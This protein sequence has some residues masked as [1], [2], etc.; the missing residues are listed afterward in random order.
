MLSI[1][2]AAVKLYIVAALAFASVIAILGAAWLASVALAVIA[3]VA[4]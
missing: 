1:L 3:G 4:A 2:Q